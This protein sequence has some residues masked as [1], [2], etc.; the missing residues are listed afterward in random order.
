M[1]RL[2]RTAGQTLSLSEVRAFFNGKLDPAVAGVDGSSL[3]HYLR[4]GGIVPATSQGG[5]ATY[6]T[7]GG[8][9]LDDIGN[10][11]M[12]NNNFYSWPNTAATLQGQTADFTY[13]AG[14]G[15][16]TGH[17]VQGSVTNNTGSGI[18]LSNCNLTLRIT[19]NSFPSS[20]TFN[21]LFWVRRGSTNVFFPDI[22]YTQ[23]QLGEEM[24]ISLSLIHI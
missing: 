14:G 6:P 1:A 21:P 12:A 18:V 19:V 7:T 22:P 2:T 13:G 8:W 16:G 11:N 15:S 20:A 24:V 4:D 9:A 5:A 17:G 10:G 23:T 3:S